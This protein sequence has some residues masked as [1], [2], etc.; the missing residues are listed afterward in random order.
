M[1][2]PRDQQNRSLTEG[3][4]EERQQRYEKRSVEVESVSFSSSYLISFPH[5][6]PFIS[7][8][9]VVSQ[10]PSVSV[11]TLSPFFSL[12]R[13]AGITG[14]NRRPYSSYIMNGGPV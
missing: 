13:G 6:S 10:A 3:T 12:Q 2:R 11:L 4:E 1:E 9:S 7:P 14:W 5:I 8:L